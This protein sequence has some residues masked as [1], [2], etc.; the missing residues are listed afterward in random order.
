MSHQRPRAQSRSQ[1]YEYVRT[2][3]QKVKN[4]SAHD[5]GRG[6]GK[7]SPL[8]DTRVVCE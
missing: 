1:A 8:S 3:I 4:S 5:Y 7:L 2:A 6:I